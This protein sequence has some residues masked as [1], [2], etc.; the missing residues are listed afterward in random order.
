ME[1]KQKG[2]EE[3]IQKGKRTRRER[4]KGQI[5]LKIKNTQT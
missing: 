2:R 1:Y 4:R 5:G 3:I